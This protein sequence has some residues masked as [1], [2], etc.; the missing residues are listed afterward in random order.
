MQ[1]RREREM[2]L[3]MALGA[4]PRQAGALV[5]ATAARI[6]GFGLVLAA[7]L[8]VPTFRWL[9][10]QLFD[11]DPAGFWTLFAAAALVSAAAGL[12]AAL[13]PV[14]RATRVAPMQALRYE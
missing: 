6:V 3:R 9:R 10:S 11:I 13:S 8:A 1:Q 7:L 2:G 4:S 14:R 5:L 12:V